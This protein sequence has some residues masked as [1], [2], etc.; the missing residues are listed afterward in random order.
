VT[1]GGKGTAVAKDGKM[2]VSFSMSMTTEDNR[3]WLDALRELGSGAQ[4]VVFDA[5]LNAARDAVLN[6]ARAP[7]KPAASTTDAERKRLKL[8]DEQ[9]P[10]D[11]LLERMEQAAGKSV[12]K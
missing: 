2:V 3:A 12:G 10:S 5:V 9:Q 4:R 6:A 8:L 7:K 11:T 1:K